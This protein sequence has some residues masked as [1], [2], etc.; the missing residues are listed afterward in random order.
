MGRPC[1]RIVRQLSNILIHLSGGNSEGVPPV[2]IPNTAVKPFSADDTPGATPRES[3]SPPESYLKDRF[4]SA[5]KNRKLNNPGLFNRGIQLL[6]FS[7]LFGYFRDQWGAP[8]EESGLQTL[9]TRHV[10]DN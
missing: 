5:H 9:R 2:P 8:S 6:R 10:S 4:K 1:E 3:R 7:Q